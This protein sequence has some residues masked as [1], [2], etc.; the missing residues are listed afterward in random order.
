[1]NKEFRRLLTEKLKDFTYL[2]ESDAPIQIASPEDVSELSFDEFFGAQARM[3]ENPKPYRELRGFIQANTQRGRIVQKI[4]ISKVEY[5]YVVRCKDLSGAV[6]PL[7][8][9]TIET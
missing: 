8:T 1:M 9:R 2:S 7:T 6:L 5:L 3:L 4:Q